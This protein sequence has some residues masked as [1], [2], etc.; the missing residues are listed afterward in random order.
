MES[1][2]Q[3]RIKPIRTKTLRKFL[4][5][6]YH[7]YV[8]KSG[9]FARVRK[10]TVTERYIAFWKLI[11]EEELPAGERYEERAEGG[12][13]WIRERER[14]LKPKIWPGIWRIQTALKCS[15]ATAQDYLRA[16]QVTRKY[17]VQHELQKVRKVLVNAAECV[18]Q[19]SDKKKREGK[20]KEGFEP[21]DCAKILRE[22]ASRLI[23]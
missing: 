3:S 22:L 9:E 6:Y 11:P 21:E 10:T 13:W 18:E 16:V 7:A 1:E 8:K 23:H 20:G 12:F 14:I 4:K 5:I 19:I 2:F 15:K 17:F